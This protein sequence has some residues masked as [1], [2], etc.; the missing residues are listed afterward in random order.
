M[1]EGALNYYLRLN[2]STRSR[3]PI[4]PK[5]SNACTNALTSTDAIRVNGTTTQSGVAGND[6]VAHCIAGRKTDTKI[7]ANPIHTKSGL[8]LCPTV[9]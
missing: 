1:R 6:L 5:A 3:R 9:E 8:S 2:L 7:A 4:V